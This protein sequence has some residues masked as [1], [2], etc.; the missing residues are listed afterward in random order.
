LVNEEANGDETAVSGNRRA[1]VLASKSRIATHGFEGLRT[2]DVAADAGVNIGTLHYYF[3]SKEALIRAAVRHTFAKFFATLSPAGTPADQLRGHLRNLR[4]LLKTDQEL[5]AVASE[6]ALRAA[7]D[8]AMADLARHADDQWFA[9]LVG[10]VERG[11]DQGCLH[12]SLA[13]EGVAATLIA[14]IKGLSMPTMGS[15]RPERIDQTLDQLE[16]WLGLSTAPTAE[17]GDS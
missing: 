13:P 12:R 1:L 7:R 11:V 14:A 17:N 5:W 16:R 8:E 4:Q 9:F 10:L 2:R 6:V 15:F 3:P